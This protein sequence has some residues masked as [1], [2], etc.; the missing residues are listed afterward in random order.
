MFSLRRR[1]SSP[2]LFRQRARPTPTYKTNII[3]NPATNTI[4][5]ATNLLQISSIWQQIPSIWQ[6][7]SSLIW[8]QIP[9]IWQQKLREGCRNKWETRFFV[10]SNPKRVLVASYPDR[11]LLLHITQNKIFGSSLFESRCLPG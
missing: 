8:Q 5:L 4:N 10:A 9:P 11:D 6:Q 7:I 3:T 1:P 2:L